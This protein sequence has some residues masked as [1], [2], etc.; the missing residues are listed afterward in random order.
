MSLEISSG[1]QC[2]GALAVGTTAVLA[3]P[4]PVLAT[5]QRR[6]IKLVVGSSPARTRRSEHVPMSENWPLQLSRS[7]LFKTKPGAA[8]KR[9]RERIARRSLRLRNLHWHH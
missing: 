8:G 4:S 9:C 6:P 3:A 1:N 7:P 5:I 2:L